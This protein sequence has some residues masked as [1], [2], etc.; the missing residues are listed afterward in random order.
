M[1]AEKQEPFAL[2]VLTLVRVQYLKIDTHVNN[3]ELV[4]VSP[5]CKEHASFLTHQYSRSHVYLSV[6]CACIVDYWE[7]SCFLWIVENNVRFPINVRKTCLYHMTRYKL[8]SHRFFYLYIILNDWTY[9]V[10]VQASQL[11]EDR[12]II[13]HD[14]TSASIFSNFIESWWKITK[15]IKRIYLEFRLQTEYQRLK[16]YVPYKH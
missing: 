4:P 13:H 9:Y 1:C 14:I 12:E 2:L 7:V 15:S 11:I 6:V 5:A 8:V 16:F 3:K 10:H